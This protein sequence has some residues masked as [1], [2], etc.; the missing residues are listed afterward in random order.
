[1]DKARCQD[2]WL[3][4]LKPMSRSELSLNFGNGVRP[5]AALGLKDPIW[6]L[7]ALVSLP[8]SIGK[9]ILV[10]KP[11]RS[12]SLRALSRSRA[13]E[14]RENVSQTVGAPDRQPVGTPARNLQR[15]L[16][17]QPALRLKTPLIAGRPVGLTTGPNN[18]FG[19]PTAW[20]LGNKDQSDDAR[21]ENKSKHLQCNRIHHNTRVP[22]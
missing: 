10:Q 22:A 14:R 6:R 4:V 16:F 5:R 9:V 1:M 18:T 15:G 7:G 20:L 21:A 3:G 11:D 12:L 13:C 19:W 17:N 2:N 8:Y